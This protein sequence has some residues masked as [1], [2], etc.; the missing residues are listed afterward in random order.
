MIPKKLVFH[1]YAYDSETYF[2]NI[3]Y[4]FHMQCLK[5]YS[6]LFNKACFNISCDNINNIKQIQQIKHD[7]INCGFNDIEIIVTEND[8]YCE[9]NTFKYFILDRLGTDN[10]LC[11]FAHTKGICNVIDGIN[12]PENILH[13]VYT[14][15]FCNLEYFYVQNME[16]HLIHSIGGK[17]NTFYGTLKNSDE[18]GSYYSGTFYWINVLKL[19]EDNKQG[20]IVI[21]KI[22]NRNFCEELPQIY[23]DKD[24]PNNNVASFWDVTNATEW[25]YNDND[26]NDIALKLTLNE[27]TVE[28]YNNV[29]NNMRSNI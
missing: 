11:F 25:L 19:Y 6:Q 4:K 8:C 14:M 22:F 2:D 21:P 15:Y 12:Y 5:R 27:E 13:W 9:A 1:I 23:F 3:A 18:Y 26:W 28:Y 29:Y 16:K 7:L 17:K 10:H 20:R 24:D